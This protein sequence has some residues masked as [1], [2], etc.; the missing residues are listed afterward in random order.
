VDLVSIKP[1]ASKLYLESVKRTFTLR[2]F[3]LE[4]E[5]WL[6]QEYGTEGVQKVFDEINLKEI[7]RIAYRVIVPEDRR[8]FAK[9]EVNLID[10]EGNEET[11]TIGGVALLQTMV[12]GWKD[13]EAVIMA[14]L[15]C[16]GISR[17]DVDEIYDQVIDGEKKSPLK[18][19]G[20]K[21]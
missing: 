20:V 12:Q 16:I 2:P 6:S 1:K 3:T 18:P 17:N 14:L 8:F 7:A 21:S 19:T 13:K 11:K 4:D 5:I 9:R 15:E 10:E